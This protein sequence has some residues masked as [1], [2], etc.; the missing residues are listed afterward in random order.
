MIKKSLLSNGKVWC[1]NTDHRYLNVTLM[2]LTF[3]LVVFLGTFEMRTFWMLELSWYSYL[4]FH[5]NEI[6]PAGPPVPSSECEGL[7]PSSQPT[8]VSPGAERISPDTPDTPS[9][10]ACR[11][12]RGGAAA[13]R[14]RRQPRPPPPS[15]RPDTPAPP[16][17]RLWISPSTGSVSRS[18]RFSHLHCCHLWSTFFSSYF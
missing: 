11:R 17:S 2:F 1:L 8:C 3:W 9:P 14:R 16:P 12:N 7:R 5:S 10:A 18:F 15:D 4:M 6:V 13:D